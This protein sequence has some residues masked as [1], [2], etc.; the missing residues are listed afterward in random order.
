MVLNA[1]SFNISSPLYPS[2]YP[3]NVNCVWKIVNEMSYF[4]VLTFIN[5]EIDIGD[6]LLFG[7]GLE[8]EAIMVLK[9]EVG[10]PNTLTTNT[11]HTWIVFKSNDAGRSTGFAVQIQDEELYGKLN[12]KKLISFP[13]NFTNNPGNY[14]GIFY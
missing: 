11:S 12:F 3:D 6:E 14:I 10:F 4:T 7:I 1:T 9:G 13:N 5:V 2:E 8:F